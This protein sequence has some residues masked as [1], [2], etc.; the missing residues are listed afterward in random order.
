MLSYLIVSPSRPIFRLR[1]APARSARYCTDDVQ[2]D[3][4]HTGAHQR[5]HLGWISTC[6][7]RDDKQKWKMFQAYE[8]SFQCKAIHW[9]SRLMAG[10]S[11]SATH[12][13]FCCSGRRSQLAYLI[14]TTARRGGPSIRL[15]KLGAGVLD[16]R[17]AYRQQG[18][19]YVK[20]CS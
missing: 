10:Q 4:P 19:R 2:Y 18:T 20:R 9:R 13:P 6:K 8:L 7:F 17:M 16:E 5:S 3:P 15:G 1:R 12:V 11:T 14:K